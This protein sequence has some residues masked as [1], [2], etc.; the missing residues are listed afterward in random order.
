MEMK[1]LLVGI[2]FLVPIA[3]CT[4]QKSELILRNATRD[5]LDAVVVEVSG[6]KILVPP[7]SSSES[8]QVR[9][10]P[11][12]DS[13]IAVHFVMAGIRK[14]C[15]LNVYV[16]NADWVKAQAEIRD[17]GQCAVVDVDH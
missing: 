1:Q 4:P 16:T 15:S 14:S 7:I 12:R 2:L 11:D 3:A 13:G 9:F 6:Q 17:G 5:R 8:V 10:L